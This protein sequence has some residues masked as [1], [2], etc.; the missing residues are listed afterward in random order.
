MTLTEKPDSR[1]SLNFELRVQPQSSQQP[2]RA[3]LIHLVEG[4]LSRR[5]EFV[6]PLELA[7][8]LANLAEQEAV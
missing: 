7:R 5:F 6:S 1:L 3:V 8:Y 2:W 4:R